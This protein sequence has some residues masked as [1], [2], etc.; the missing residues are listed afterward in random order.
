MYSLTPVPPLPSPPSPLGVLLQCPT[1][2][3]HTIT[4]YASPA[5]SVNLGPAYWCCQQS[6]LWEREGR[7][8]GSGRGGGWSRGIVVQR[9]VNKAR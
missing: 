8:R 9:R 4:V 1:A 7:R 2:H 5:Q 3:T 6:R